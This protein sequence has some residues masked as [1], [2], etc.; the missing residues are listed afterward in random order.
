[1]SAQ[2]RDLGVPSVP[3]KAGGVGARGCRKAA[4]EAAMGMR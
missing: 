2:L 4:V 1:M 3:V